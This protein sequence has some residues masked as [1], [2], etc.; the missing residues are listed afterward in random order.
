[1]NNTDTIIFMSAYETTKYSKSRRFF[2]K[3]STLT[4]L[5]D[6]HHFTY[7]LKDD[8]LISPKGTLKLCAEY[9]YIQQNTSFSF[10]TVTEKSD[11]ASFEE[12]IKKTGS[13]IKLL[14][15]QSVLSDPMY[16]NIDFFIFMEQ[17]LVYVG[18]HVFQIDPVIFSLNR[19]LMISFEVIDFKTGTP[20]KKDN[21]LGKM[22]NYNLLS[23]NGYQYFGEEFVTPSNSKISELIYDNISSFFYELTGKRFVPENYSFIHNTLVLSNDIIDVA[24]YFCNLIGTKEIPSPLVN[25]STTDNYQY[26]PQDGASVIT[27]YNSNNVDISLYNGILLES[28]KLYIYLTQIINLEITS[29]I[30]KVMRNNLYLENLFFAPHVPIE[31]HNLLSYIYKTNSFQHHKEATKLKI[32]YMTAENESKKSRNGVLLNVLLYIVSLIGAIGTLDTLE[33]RL[34]IPFN[35]SFSAVI[36]IFSIFGII[37]G[38]TEWRRNKR[39]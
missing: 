8:K 5:M 7:I 34:N 16:F 31:T 33:Y 12:V 24:E 29:D 13:C 22:G 36:L 6:K 25:I 30:N 21:V 39:F 4:T 3:S 35:Y 1:M 37:W 19:A 15:A 17:F 10:S 20:L 9:D 27:K 2:R 26:Y 38:M 28:I 14:H 18:D 32:S 11:I 23:I